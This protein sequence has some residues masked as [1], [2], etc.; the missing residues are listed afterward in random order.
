MQSNQGDGCTNQAKGWSSGWSM[1][2][3]SG[4]AWTAMQPTHYREISETWDLPKKT[5][6][7]K[8]YTLLVDFCTHLV[9]HGDMELLRPLQQL[10]RT[11]GYLKQKWKFLSRFSHF[12]G[13]SLHLWVNKWSLRQ[14][15]LLCSVAPSPHLGNSAKLSNHLPHLTHHPPLT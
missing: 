4:T 5:I 15:F 2:M 13:D 14:H 12:L 6:C 8:F 11:S 7:S 3:R 10:S 9:C 1:K